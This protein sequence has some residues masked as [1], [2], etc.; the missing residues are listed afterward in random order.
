MGI[1]DKC[2]IVGMGCTKFGE[3]WDKSGDDLV[4]EA[5]TEALEDAGIHLK[6]IQAGW[7]GSMSTAWSGTGLVYP[8]S[9]DFIPATRVENKC[10]SGVEALKEACFAVA[11]G[12]YDIVLAV[13]MEKLKDSG[14]SGLF[15]PTS[16]LPSGPKIPLN[17]T[18]PGS[19]AQAANRYF[20]Q[21]KINPEEGKRAMARIAVKNHYNGSLHPKA[22]FQREVT[23]EQVMKA[24]IVAWPL[25]LLDCCGVTDG[26]AAAI[27]TRPDI[28]RSLKK[29]Y[30]LVKGFGVSVG[31]LGAIDQNYDF[32]HWEETV[33]ASRMAYQEVGIRDPAKEISLAEVHDCFTITELVTYEDLGFCP[34]GS[35]KDY[36]EEGVFTLKGNL[37]VNTDGGLKAFGHPIAASGLRMTYEIYKQL[38]HKAGPRQLKDPQLGLVHCQGGQPGEFNCA[39]AIF[40]R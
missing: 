7:I 29:D 25:G 21:F 20:Y 26:A 1:K 8:L 15:P 16:G 31:A 5:V 6:E 2:A 24:P 9:L 18:A 39:V 34:K 23:L 19:Y 35:A 27:V 4:V 33:K 12:E 3:L 36:V 40:G 11:A 32:V 37:P 13:G 14:A 10:A 28:A 22:Q 38:L 30:I 17:R